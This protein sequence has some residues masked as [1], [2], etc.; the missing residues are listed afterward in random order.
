MI[1]AE[2][3]EL[4]RLVRQAVFD[5]VQQEVLTY[6]RPIATPTVQGAFSPDRCQQ[7]YTYL[8]SLERQG[9]I[10]RARINA[11]ATTKAI[12][13]WLFGLR[14]VCDECGKADYSVVWLHGNFRHNDW[15]HEFIEGS[16]GW[17]CTVPVKKG[18]FSMTECAIQVW[19]RTYQR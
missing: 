10:V 12:W 1:T 2:A 17:A 9:Q 15:G 6:G 16:G 13:W 8:I 19:A 11:G 14:P 4:N 18:K 3:R 7:V 5:T